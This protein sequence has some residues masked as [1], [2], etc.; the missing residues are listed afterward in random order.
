MEKKKKK[1]INFYQMKIE[2]DKL[3]F[4]VKFFLLSGI[5]RRKGREGHKLGITR[6]SER[7]AEQ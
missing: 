1:T 7:D 6:R 2:R 5:E 3:S 4:W